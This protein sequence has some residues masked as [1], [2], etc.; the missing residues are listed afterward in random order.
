MTVEEE[1]TAKK[2]VKKQMPSNVN[3]AIQFYSQRWG[4]PEEEAAKQIER[5]LEKRHGPSMEDLYPGPVGPITQKVM[6]VNQA[7]LSSA[8]TKRRI[9]Q[10]ENPQ[11]ESVVKDSI[12]KTV[13]EVGTK[14]IQDKLTAK[15]PVREAADKALATIVEDAITAK[16]Q[17]TDKEALAAA[18]DAKFDEFNEKIIKP[19]FDSI[20]EL[21]K[22]SAGKEKDEG[23]MIPVSKVAEKVLEMQDE[24]KRFLEGR[25]YKIEATSTDKATVEKM[26][27]DAVEKERKSLE[28]L[29]KQKEEQTGYNVQL[30]TK[31]IDATEKIL[32]GLTDRLFKVF[33][34]PMKDKIQ[35]AL[36]KGTLGRGP[37]QPQ[38]GR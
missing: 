28:E 23:E 21:Q 14:I 16:L 8:E 1:P 18:M 10:M 37:P 15:D 13:A 27:N 11:Q 5:I 17:G 12:D 22:N 7:L 2:T 25:G 20:Q 19:L 6:D 31:R 3:E 30:E 36:E 4:V 26:I 34:E 33:I 9:Q 35:E 29:Y 38:P 32:D 24:A